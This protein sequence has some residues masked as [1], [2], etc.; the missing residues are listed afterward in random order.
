MITREGIST[1]RRGILAALTRV[2]C[3][4]IGASMTAESTAASPSMP[5]PLQVWGQMKGLAPSKP[6]EGL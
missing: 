3:E 2:G 4:A 6:G 5:P 1:A